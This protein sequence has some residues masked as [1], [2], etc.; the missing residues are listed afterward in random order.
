[1]KK[2]TP[3]ETLHAQTPPLVEEGGEVGGFSGHCVPALSFP[4]LGQSLFLPGFKENRWLQT[5]TVTLI[6]YKVHSSCY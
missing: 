5:D 6:R 4:C 1:M 2:N 3:Q